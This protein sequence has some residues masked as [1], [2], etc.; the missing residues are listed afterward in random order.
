M[1]YLYDLIAVHVVLIFDL[2][3]KCMKHL[4]SFVTL[5]LAHVHLTQSHIIAQL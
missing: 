3:Y 5:I 1:K 2:C 4:Y